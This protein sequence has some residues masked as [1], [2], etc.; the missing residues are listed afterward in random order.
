MQAEAL[1]YT[2]QRMTAPRILAIDDDPVIGALIAAT[3]Q[4]YD[5]TVVGSGEEGLERFMAAPFDLAICD[6]QLPGIDGMEV[7]RRIRQAHPGARVMVVSVHGEPANLLAG[8][9]QNV[10]DFIVKPFSPGNLLCTVKN[11]LEEQ[12]AIEVI[13]A[14]PKWIELQIPASFQVAASLNQFFANLQVDLDEQT[15]TSVGTAFRELVNNAIEHGA[16]GNHNL[17]VRISCV[18]LD[19]AIVYRI[20]DPGPGFDPAALT[21][22]AISYPDDPMKHIEVRHEKG[23]RA[24]GF[25]MLWTQSLADEV[26]Y[27]EK[28]NKVM[29]VKYLG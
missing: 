23:L 17:K 14:T 25:G 21:H 10:V 20:E 15:R 13:S 11:L 9:R 22:A 7:I 26:V 12:A 6:L 18:R 16:K 29:F 3:L 1:C 24:G 8:L 19:R 28:H 4:D 27:D 2:P 5:V